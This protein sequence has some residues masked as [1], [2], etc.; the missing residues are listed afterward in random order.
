[1]SP[2]LLRRISLLAV[3]MRRTAGARGAGEKL[4]APLRRI[5]PV[6]GRGQ[7]AV[8]HSPTPPTPHCGAPPSG[9]QGCWRTTY[10]G[11]AA[12]MARRRREEGKG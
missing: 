9:R 5:P 11:G 4:S 8:Q 10:S 3:Q 2:S 1:M 7:R 12:V 6:G